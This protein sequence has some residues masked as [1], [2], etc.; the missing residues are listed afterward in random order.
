MNQHKRQELIRRILLDGP[1][2]SQEELRKRLASLGVEATQATISRDIRAMGILK[3]PTG[4]RL[5]GDVVEEGSVRPRPCPRGSRGGSLREH[6]VDVA[7][8]GTLVVVSTAPGYAPLVALEIDT[9]DEDRIVGTVAGNDT[10]FVATVSVSDGEAVC[11]RL[12][13]ATGLRDGSSAPQPAE[14]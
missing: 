2:A 11:E 13:E 5:P 12:R 6:S 7:T 9:M 4:Y 1:L 10:V 8:A 14:R 3:G